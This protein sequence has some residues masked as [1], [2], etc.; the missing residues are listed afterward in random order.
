MPTSSAW[1][2]GGAP[3]FEHTDNFRTCPSWDIN[4]NDE[5]LETVC[6]LIILLEH[7]WSRESGTL[8]VLVLLSELSAW[9]TTYGFTEGRLWIFRW[10]FLY[11]F[12]DSHQHCSFLPKAFIIFLWTYIK[13][14]LRQRFV[15]DRWW[16]GT[17]YYQFTEA[18]WGS[19]PGL[20]Q[21]RICHLDL[22][23]VLQS[24]HKNTSPALVSRMSLPS[25]SPVVSPGPK[26]AQQNNTRWPL[27]RCPARRKSET[28]KLVVTR[29]F[30]LIFSGRL[31]RILR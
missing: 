24:A 14:S 15:C 18:Q 22:P 21:R 26:Y 25:G 20:R 29:P 16:V 17:V 10:Q 8:H 6:A 31:A 9:V 13:M 3:F 5:L 28:S 7:S 4:F 19:F 23:S 12:P 30:R 27:D 2:F 11:F 1:S